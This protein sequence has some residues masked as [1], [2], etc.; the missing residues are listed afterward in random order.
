MSKVLVRVLLFMRRFGL[1]LTVGGRFLGVPKL[2]WFCASKIK[3]T[4]PV[5][6]FDGSFYVS[7][8]LSE[9]MQRRIFWLGY[10]NLQMVP[11]IRSKLGPGMVFLDIGANIGE[12]SMVAAKCVGDKGCVIAFEPISSISDILELNITRNNLSQVVVERS[13]ISNVVSSGIPIYK[14][15]GQ[16]QFEEEND[17]LG[18]IVCTESN[19]VP[20][21]Y[22]STTTIDYYIE[23]HEFKRI[24][25]IKIDVEGAELQCLMGASNT[26]HRFKPDLIVEVQDSTANA[27]GYE[28][29]DILEYLAQFGYNFYRFERNGKTLPIDPASLGSVQN[30]LCIAAPNEREGAIKKLKD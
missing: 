28:A 7:L 12:I 21:E 19:R 11:Y 26:L 15:C 30:V 16:E 18:T 8:R 1:L 22:I 4:I 24:D 6:D 27:A 13:G 17:G 3:L 9:H 25:L 10:Y 23:A 2:F 20:V 29:R 5:S 14:S